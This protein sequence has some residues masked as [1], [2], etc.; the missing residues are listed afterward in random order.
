MSDWAPGKGTI[1]G[2]MLLGILFHALQIPICAL[3]VAAVYMTYPDSWDV[4][5][6]FAPLFLIGIS[7]LVY[8]VPAIVYQFM[9]GRSENGKGL[10][11]AASITFLLNAGCYGGLVFLLRDIGPSQPPTL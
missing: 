5:L 7:Q 2:G 4:S 9:K 3:V 6:G 1:R 11:V 10:I 8:M